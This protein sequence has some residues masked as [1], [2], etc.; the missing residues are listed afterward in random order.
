MKFHKLIPAIV[1]CIAMTAQAQNLLSNPSFETPGPGFVLFQDW[2]NF[3][4]VFDDVSVEFTAQD[5]TTSAKMFGQF[6]SSQNDQVLLQTVTSVVVGMQYTLSA[7]A[8]HLTGDEVQTGNIVLLQLN[9]QDSAGNNLEQVQTDAIVPGQTPPDQWN[10]VEV[11]GIA[12]AGTTQILVA[13]LHLQ[14]DGVAGGASF[15]DNISLVEGDAPCTN[16]A[17]FNHDGIIDFFD[18]QAFLNAFAKGCP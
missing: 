17:D 9:F 11:S 6:S 3:G 14:I 13:L 1:G 2:E 12:P 16:P 4:N 15:W 10:Q 8:A 18:V 7:Y 5:G